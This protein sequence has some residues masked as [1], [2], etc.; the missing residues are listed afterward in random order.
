MKT[1]IKLFICLTVLTFLNNPL[2]AQE[3]DTDALTSLKK[4]STALLFEIDRDLYINSYIGAIISAKKHVT[5]NS[6]LRFGLSGTFNFSSTKN[7][8]IHKDANYNEENKSNGNSQRISVN[9]EYLYYPVTNKKLT[10]FVGAGPSISYNH[11]YSRNYILNGLDSNNWDENSRSKRNEWSLG[12]DSS[13][14]IEIFIVNYIGLI[15]EYGLTATYRS[16]NNKTI[17]SEDEYRSDGESKSF[18]LD[19]QSKKIGLS[20]YF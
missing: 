10:F 6:S 2:E 1:L 19:S 4:G 3:K 14:G 20:F 9:I 17:Y 5:D 18:G 11:N 15:A 12:L 7:K 16:S 13:V 8:S